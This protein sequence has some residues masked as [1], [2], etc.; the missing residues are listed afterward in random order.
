M[1]PAQEAVNQSGRFADLTLADLRERER[2]TAVAIAL[3]DRQDPVPSARHD[4][5]ATLDA[6]RA[7]IAKRE[8]E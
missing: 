4:M 2:E 3:F 1:T 7:E 5:Q 8:A 6:V